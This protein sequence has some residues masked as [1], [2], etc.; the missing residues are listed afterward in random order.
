MDNNE[1]R[2]LMKLLHLRPDEVYHVF[3]L[4][5][6]VGGTDGVLVDTEGET[7]MRIGMGLGLSPDDIGALAE[8]AVLAIRET[9]PTDVISYSVAT[10]KTKL[11]KDQLEG[12]QVILKFV[13]MS[14]RKLDDE[15]KDLLR[16]IDEAWAE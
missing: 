2:K 12:V 16:V 6:C 9:S 3:C 1:T 15:E 5:L 11:T 13:A 7:L 4:A 8:N 10:L 14:D